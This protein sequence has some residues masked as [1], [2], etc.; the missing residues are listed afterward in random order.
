MSTAKRLIAALLCCI[1]LFFAAVRL[2]VPEKNRIVEDEELPPASIS[3]LYRDAGSIILCECVYVLP[4]GESFSGSLYIIKEVIDGSVEKDRLIRLPI[5]AQPGTEYLLYLYQ[6]GDTVKLMTEQPIPVVDGMVTLENESCSYQSVVRDIERQKK[7]LT[8]PSQS[9]Y[10]GEFEA[11]VAAC[12]EIAACRVLSISDPTETVC[13]SGD[14]GE[15][16]LSTMNQVFVTLKVETGYSGRLVRGDSIEAALSPLDAVPIINARDLSPKNAEVPE[17]HW[18]ESGGTYIFFL[19]RS[20]DQKS[21]YYFLVNPFEGYVPV[22]GGKL[23]PPEYNESFA[24]IKELG[25]FNKKLREVF[26]S[27]EAEE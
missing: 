8:I 14:K 19:L 7:I 5:E 13:R 25:E 18:L 11:L 9:F 1:I 22:R 23:T 27:G 26:E 12:D 16:T 10:Y 17:Q 24:G 4:E 21:A 6:E 3:R 2:P 15:S 20:T